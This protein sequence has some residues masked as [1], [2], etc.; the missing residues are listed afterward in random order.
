MFLVGLISWW[1]GRGWIGQLQRMGLRFKATVDFFSIPQLVATLFSPFRQISAGPSAEA[2]IAG[3]FRS[4][5]DKLVSRLIGG[6]VRSMTILAGLFVIVLQSVYEVLVLIG[7]WLLP[8]LPLVGLVLVAI[9]W[10]PSW[11]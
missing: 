2:G 6:F 1:Y 8:V 3:A 10:V 11:M 5:L 7:W 4:F 9:G